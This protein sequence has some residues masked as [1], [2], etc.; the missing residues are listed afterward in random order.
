MR[1][2]PSSAALL[3]RAPLA[4]V[5]SAAFLASPLRRAPLATMSAAKRVLV[6]IADDSEDIETACITDVLVRAGAEVTVASVMPSL[7]VRLARGLKLTADCSIDDCA[8]AEWDA[9]ACPGGMPGAEN[10]RDSAALTALLKKQASAGKL[11]AAVCASPA[12]IFATHGILNGPATCYPAPQFKEK[13]DGWTD[14]QAVVD[15]HILT[16]QGPGTSLQFALKIVEELYGRPKAEELA[17][18]LLTHLA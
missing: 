9:I 12:V 1:L 17:A 14:A 10:L 18:G 8:S 6:P 2:V 3:H 5:W 7:Q 13:I 11:T 16:S 15:G 4:T